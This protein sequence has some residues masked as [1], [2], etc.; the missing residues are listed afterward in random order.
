MAAIVITRNFPQYSNFAH[1]F[2][3]ADADVLP[4]Y[5]DM[6]NG[7]KYNT[8]YRPSCNVVLRNST[9]CDFNSPKSN[10]VMSVCVEKKENY[11]DIICMHGAV[12]KI[13]F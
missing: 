1:I 13:Y 5:C 12:I 8:F 3:L 9:D 4:V 11:P 10:L 7:G 2:Q 6:E